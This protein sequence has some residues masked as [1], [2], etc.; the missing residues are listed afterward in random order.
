MIVWVTEL[1]SRNDNGAA[2]VRVGDNDNSVENQNDEM[3]DDTAY[4]RPMGDEDVEA[5]E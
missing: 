5:S 4:L 2:V 3:I 1:L